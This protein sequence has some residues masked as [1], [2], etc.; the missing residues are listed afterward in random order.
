MIIAQLCTSG[1][2]IQRIFIGETTWQLYEEKRN[3]ILKDGEKKLNFTWIELIFESEKTH[4][5]TVRDKNLIFVRQ[6]IMR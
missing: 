1:K 4:G 6:L 5:L 3:T 2:N